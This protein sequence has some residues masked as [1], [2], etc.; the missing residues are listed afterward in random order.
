[1]FYRF[2]HISIYK[3]ISRLVY[4]QK[5]QYSLVWCFIKSP[6]THTFLKGKDFVLDYLY[7]SKRLARNI[8]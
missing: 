3:Q 2:K 8:E 7:Y 4:T 1:M 5:F 6:L